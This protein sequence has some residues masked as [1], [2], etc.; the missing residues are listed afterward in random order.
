MVT[1]MVSPIAREMARMNDAITP[2]SAAGT[3]VRVATSNLVAPSAYAP[4]RN[5]RGTALKASSE[6]EDTIGMIITPITML[7]DRAL[8][9]SVSGKKRLING[10]TKNSAK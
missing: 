1:I 9:G 5:E 7:A 3:T 6:S 10:V 4:S 8:K 2:D